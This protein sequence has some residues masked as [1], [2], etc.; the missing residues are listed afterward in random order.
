MADATTFVQVLQD[1]DRFVLGKFAVKQGTAL[2]FGEA[3]LASP[4]SQHPALFL[5]PITEA[6]TEVLQTPSAVIGASRVLAAEGFQVVYGTSISARARKKVGQP[7]E[8][9]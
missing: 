7:L 4:A 8:L 1:A 3:L 9:P 6:D 2:A 5:H